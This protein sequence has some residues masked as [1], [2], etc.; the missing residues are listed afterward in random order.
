MHADPWHG[1]GGSSG[2][3]SGSSRQ[4]WLLGLAYMA[5]LAVASPAYALGGKKPAKD[6]ALISDA[7]M[8][9]MMELA[10]PVLSNMGVSGVLGMCA[11]AALKVR[12]PAALWGRCMWDCA[13]V[14]PRWCRGA[15]CT[16]LAQD[17]GHEVPAIACTA[18]GR[19][20]PQLA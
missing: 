10:G 4:A 14:R 16:C 8:E 5:S 20:G 15:V 1:G 11:A 6:E 19:S 7:Y 2:G 9:Q 13:R 18:Q 3:S 12:L 17:D